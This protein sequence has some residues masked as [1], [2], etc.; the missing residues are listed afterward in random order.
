MPIAFKPNETFRNDFAYR[1]SPEAIRR[2]PFPFDQ[3]AYMYS[4]NIEPHTPGPAGSLGSRF[5]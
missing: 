5:W 2:F 4:V 3:D 1:N